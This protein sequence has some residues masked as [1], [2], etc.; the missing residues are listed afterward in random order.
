MSLGVQKLIKHCY[1]HLVHFKQW[2]ENDRWKGHLSP[3]DIHMSLAVIYRTA[4]YFISS[5]DYYCV[6]IKLWHVKARKETILMF[7]FL[8][9]TTFSRRL[10]L[11]W[12]H[13]YTWLPLTCPTQNTIIISFVTI[14]HVR[15][16]PPHR[17]LSITGLQ[18]MNDQWSQTGL[19]ARGE[20]IELVD[21]WSLWLSKC[22]DFYW[23]ITDE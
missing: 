23:P 2:Q 20:V 1:N 12:R 13:F 22:E 18:W 21:L 17:C 14:W 6:N 4:I 3:V 16:F 15:W 9:E 10:I 7:W 19:M 5:S 8:K 11:T